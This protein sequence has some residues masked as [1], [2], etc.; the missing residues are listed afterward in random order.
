MAKV[1]APVVIAMVKR[2][3]AA[4]AAMAKILATAAVAAV[5]EEKRALPAQLSAADDGGSGPGSHN[6]CWRT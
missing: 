5:K 4:V 1:V 6:P 2:A 3:T